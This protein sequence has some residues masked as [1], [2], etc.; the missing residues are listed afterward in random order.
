MGESKVDS[1]DA[2]DDQAAHDQE[3]F[4]TLYYQLSE[5]YQDIKQNSQISWQMKDLMLWRQSRISK[6][7]GPA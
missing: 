1:V 6:F 7:L 5:S 3:G 2:L 4:Q